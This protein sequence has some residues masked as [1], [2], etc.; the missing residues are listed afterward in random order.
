MA[1]VLMNDEEDAEDV[2]SEDE[3]HAIMSAMRAQ[4]K[5][6]TASERG[7]SKQ[8]EQ[9]LVRAIRRSYERQA[10]LKDHLQRQSGLIQSLQSAASAPEP[11]TETTRTATPPAASPS[12]H[13]K[14]EE[15]LDLNRNLD[16]ELRL[17]TSAWYEQNSRILSNG[18][19]LSKRRPST[20]PQSFLGKQR[21]V[22]EHVMLGTGAT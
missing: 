1:A 5:A 6:D 19:L 10:K 20:E 13:L 18:V 11:P 7:V 8:V 4:A 2:V 22:V 9:K 17:M 21:R 14:L 12:S 16:R 15:A 3:L